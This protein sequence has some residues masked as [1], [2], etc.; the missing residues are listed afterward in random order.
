MKKS[1]DSILKQIYRAANFCPNGIAVEFYSGFDGKSNVVLKYKTLLSMALT[2]ATNL[3]SSGKYV[4]LDASRRSPE[5]II[6]LLGL[7]I[8]KKAF[9]PIDLD[10]WPKSRIDNLR[11][12]L[13]IDLI[14]TEK[15]IKELS[16]PYPKSLDHF[17]VLDFN[18]EDDL[19]YCICTSG[20]TGDPK[21]I[22]VSHGGIPNLAENQRKI[23]ESNFHSRFL[24]ILSPVFDGSLS[25]I[26]V[27]LSSG[28]AI[29]ID[30]SY[31]PS[32]L[33]STLESRNISIVDAPPSLLLAMLGGGDDL[34]SCVKTIVV[35]G[36]QLSEDVVRK[37]SKKCRVVNVYGPTEATICTSAKVYDSSNSDDP[38]TI[39][40]QFDGVDY[41]LYDQS[42]S[43]SE[44]LIGGRQLALGYAGDEKLTNE[45]FQRDIYGKRWFKTGDL[46]EK[47]P[48]GEWKF[49]GR[50]DR[51]F[52]VHGKLVAPEEIEAA[53]AKIGLSAAVVEVDGKIKAVI[54][55]QKL[56]NG[57]PFVKN[58]IFF[59]DILKNH[60]RDIIPE[61]MI[62]TSI[63][64]VKK[65]K[66]LSS[67][68]ID[69]KDARDA[70]NHKDDEV[71]KADSSQISCSSIEK[72]IQTMMKDILKLDFLPEK[73]KSFIKD[74]GADSI[75]QIMLSLRIKKE[76]GLQ[77]GCTDLT[78][79]DSPSKLAEL[80]ESRIYCGE[81]ASAEDLLAKARK[82]ES[83]IPESRPTTKRDVI[84]VTGA[85]GFLGS[86]VL[87]E[88]LN[89]LDEDE[90]IVCI[91][92]AED[93]WG[94][95]LKINQALDRVGISKRAKNDAE[96]KMTDLAGDLSSEK[97]GLNDEKYQYLCNHTKLV[98]HI[99]GEV[100]DW[101]AAEDLAKSNIETT[102]KIIDFC[103]TG[104]AREAKL[105]FASTLSVF[106]S[107]A[108]LPVGYRC[109]EIPLDSD[110]I[111]VGGYAQSKWIAE[112][113]VSDLMPE[114]SK[115]LRY[116]LLTE[117][118]WNPMSFGKNT[119]SMFFRG[120][121]KLGCLP[122]LPKT[123]L[124][125]DLTPV[126]FAAKATVRSASSRNKIFHIHAGMQINYGL[127]EKNLGLEKCSFTSWKEKCMEK[128]DDEDVLACYEALS[129]EDGNRFGPFDLFQSTD[130]IFDRNNMLGLFTDNENAT[131]LKNEY[132]DQILRVGK[133]KKIW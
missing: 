25:D 4:G 16:S 123:H 125:V 109:R 41:K 74:L 105:I 96:L 101:K 62:P 44:L 117:P 133:D 92:K 95:K 22:Q 56:G 89:S 21:C 70:V 34:P 54:E 2:F 7:M 5:F 20:S 116:G 64:K 84:L 124:A 120:A 46:V 113:I 122:D 1:F 6:G 10:S 61:W 17:S 88:L 66:R 18:N 75:Q 77:L 53:F 90:N 48:N 118:R 93:D 24:W 78:T 43:I 28:S 23:F 36:E 111:V 42:K 104:T 11:E 98:Y 60:L 94:A 126:D 79:N 29:V 82:I 37:Y 69:Y 19:A 38:I 80:I 26:F 9:V 47:L 91:V 127:L 102:I 87:K 110:G 76:F 51:Q 8:A 129:R 130:V 99:A 63:K 106:V 31:E 131:F 73:T 132:L 57:I 128:L 32:K 3:P 107:R 59:E 115:I 71:S 65:L 30:D 15:S 13:D 27:A 40:T 35:G 119:L 112:K 67:G 100:N 81:A 55:D 85:A 72:K 52:K 12:K 14:L 86:H 58:S 68:K 39:G 103:K 45:K 49:I 121:I 83:R 108:D 33:F 114:D 50:N 97:F